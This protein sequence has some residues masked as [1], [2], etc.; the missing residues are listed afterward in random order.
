MPNTGYGLDSLG[1]RVQVLPYNYTFPFKNLQSESYAQLRL[2]QNFGSN[3]SAFFR[4]TA[5]IANQ[6]AHESLPIMKD[7]Y[8]SEALFAT[9]SETHILSP[10]LLNTARLS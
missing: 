9:V 5:D 8:K 7:N 6:N 1:H 2:D 10:T 3:D 4:Y